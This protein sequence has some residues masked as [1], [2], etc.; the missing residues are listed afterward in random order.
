[1]LAAKRAIENLTLPIN[2]Q[3]VELGLTSFS[4]VVHLMNCKLGD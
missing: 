1:M 2:G 4:P 3:I